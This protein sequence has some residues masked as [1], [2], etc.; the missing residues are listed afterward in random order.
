MP[1]KSTESRCWTY[2]VWVGP[3]HGS[4]QSRKSEGEGA[5]LGGGLGITVLE[6]YGGLAWTVA[7]AGVLT[8]GCVAVESRRTSDSRTRTLETRDKGNDWQ[9]R[10]SFECFGVNKRKNREQ[11]GW[12]RRSLKAS[13]A[14]PSA[15]SDRERKRLASPAC[16]RRPRR[17]CRLILVGRPTT[18]GPEIERNYRQASTFF[19]ALL[20]RL[21]LNP[22][23][24]YVCTYIHTYVVAICTEYARFNGVWNPPLHLEELTLDLSSHLDRCI[25]VIALFQPDSLSDAAWFGPPKEI[26][27]KS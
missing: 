3:G 21:H 16:A 25:Q 6:Y 20:L 10:R 2:A 9:S 7:W 4:G 24:M 26:Q 22:V 12:D 14:V 11:L 13:P 15:I 8:S 1:A 19:Y 5:H 23:I 17:A 27:S 18:P